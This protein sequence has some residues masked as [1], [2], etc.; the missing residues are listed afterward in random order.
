MS[1]LSTPGRT[2]EI[3]RGQGLHFDPDMVAAFER[4]YAAGII[5]EIRSHNPSRD[6]S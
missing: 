6:K 4:L 5:S 1:E 2:D 3:R